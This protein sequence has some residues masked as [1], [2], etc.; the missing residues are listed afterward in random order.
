MEEKIIII[1]AGL[2]GL[3]AAITLNEQAEILSHP[4]LK[5]LDPKNSEKI[6]SIMIQSIEE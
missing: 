5:K 4:L 3:A 6:L 2:S 1:G